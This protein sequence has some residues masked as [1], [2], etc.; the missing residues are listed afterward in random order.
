MI[1]DNKLDKPLDVRVKHKR[2]QQVSPPP[3]HFSEEHTDVH[4]D[5]DILKL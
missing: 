3:H 1:K 5:V 4:T 2:V